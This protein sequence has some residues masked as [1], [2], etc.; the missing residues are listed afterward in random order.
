VVFVA[1]TWFTP[2]SAPGLG[3]NMGK[4]EDMSRDL[5][6]MNW[7]EIFDSKELD[8]C[9]DL[10]LKIYHELC[11]KY[12][13]LRGKNTKNSP[14]WFNRQLK[15]LIKAKHKL[16]YR[17]K[18]SKAGTIENERRKTAY[19]LICKEVEI[20]IRLVVSDFEKG[21]A[22]KAKRD[23]KLIYAYSKSKQKVKEHIRAIVDS[24]GQML[25]DSKLI[26]DALN[27]QFKLWLKS[28]LKGVI[29]RRL[30]PKRLIRLAWT[31]LWIVSW[32]LELRRLYKGLVPVRRSE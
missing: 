3:W 16:W 29:F 32:S 6:E 20:K 4:Y 24:T 25:T 1:E 30:S 31:N 10:F 11:D 27:S 21:L 23:P 9:Y 18:G 13:P 15:S 14:L 8:C 2:E 5:R 26:D 7:R 12:V 17:W 28:K 19:E 22:V